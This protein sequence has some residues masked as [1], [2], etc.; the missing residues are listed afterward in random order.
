MFTNVQAYLFQ[1][2]GVKPRKA[3]SPSASPSTLRIALSCPE[4]RWGAGSPFSYLFRNIRVK[5]KLRLSIK[6]TISLACTN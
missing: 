3:S 2:L 5:V 4:C 6:G 1:A